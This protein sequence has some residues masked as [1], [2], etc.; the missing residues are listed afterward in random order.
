MCSVHGCTGLH[1][2]WISLKFFVISNCEEKLTTNRQILK[3]A[4]NPVLFS[5]ESRTTVTMKMTLL[6]GFPAAAQSTAIQSSDQH[7]RR[8]F[9]RH[10]VL[11]FDEPVGWNGWI[12][13]SAGSP[14]GGRPSVAS[15]SDR[16]LRPTNI[17]TKN[18][19]FSILNFSQLL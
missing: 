14:P 3:H 9:H 11:V 7:Y 8:S 13:C 15:L 10:R 1:F 17:Q 19:M 2:S 16:L 18:A 12:F 6:V 5:F 4:S